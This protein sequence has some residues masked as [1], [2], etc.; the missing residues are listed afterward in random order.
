MSSLP[1]TP[2]NNFVFIHR[3]QNPEPRNYIF[4]DVVKMFLMMAGKFK[5]IFKNSHG[6]V[7]KIMNRSN[8]FNKW[9]S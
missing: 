3:I 2:D 5:D 7:L 4:D 9:T 8:N 6:D 1:T